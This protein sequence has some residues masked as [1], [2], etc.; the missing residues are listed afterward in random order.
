M[1]ET[2]LQ[3]QAFNL[4][5]RIMQLNLRFGGEGDC[6]AIKIAASLA[7]FRPQPALQMLPASLK[8]SPVNTV[9]LAEALAGGF[10]TEAIKVRDA[11][12]RSSATEV[13]YSAV[14][15][16]RLGDYETARTTMT[17]LF[18]GAPFDA[19]FVAKSLTKIDPE[20]SIAVMHR[21]MKGRPTSGN[22]FLYSE[23]VAPLATDLASSH[24]Q[25]ARE[26]FEL[27]KEDLPGSAALIAIGLE[28]KAFATEAVQRW[29]NGDSSRDL[30]AQVDTIAIKLGNHE[31]LKS[32][33]DE[34]LRTGQLNRT[35]NLAT[36]LAFVHP[37][38]GQEILLRFFQ[39]HSLDSKSGISAGTL[40]VSAALGYLEY[41]DK[42][43]SQMEQGKKRVGAGTAL[44][45]IRR[46]SD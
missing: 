35:Y 5:E 6:E 30:G 34:D 9:P 31:L 33:I 13:A 11:L 16:V 23:Y 24:P 27:I 29:I 15:S 14:I 12:H 41:T 42:V 39:E 32:L 40:Q 19:L 18:N 22:P 46:V 26:V 36:A 2:P 10:P 45:L 37:A 7:P 38:D 17:E 3:T 25:E 1:V 44:T 8:R 43:I 20:S 21:S 28:D 4:A